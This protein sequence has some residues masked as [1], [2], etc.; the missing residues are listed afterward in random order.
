VLLRL[1]EESAVAIRRVHALVN[2][3]SGGVGPGA[4]AELAALLADLGL[5]H[6]VSELTPGDCAPAVRAAVAGE[7]DLVVVLGGDGTARLVAETCGPD[8]PLV[9]PL[10]GGTMNKLGRALYGTR[11]WREALTAALTHGRPRWVPGG[12]AGG[13]AFYCGA[14]L[15]SPALLA[16]A[17]EAIRSHELGRAWRRAVIASRKALISRVSY[18]LNGATGHGVAISLICPTVSRTSRRHARALKAAVLDPPQGEARAKAG[19]RL[20]LS[21][22]IGDWRDDPEITW[23]CVSGRAWARTSIPIM[24][25]GEFFRL[26]RVVDIRFQPRAFRALVPPTAGHGGFRDGP[27][28]GAG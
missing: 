27:R 15:G 19:V 23:P 9:A 20:A 26:G 7:P 5:E 8:G 28:S 13:R 14:V 21:N 10:S 3:A 12:E 25:D 22:L 18:Q 2:P 6:Q 1:A 24:L 17:R 4:A 16:P 11:P